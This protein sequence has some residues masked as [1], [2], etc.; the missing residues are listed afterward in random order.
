MITINFYGMYKPENSTARPVAEDRLFTLTGEFKQ[1]FDISRPVVIV[2]DP[3]PSTTVYGSTFTIGSPPNYAQINHDAGQYGGSFGYFWIDQIVWVSDK[4]VEVHMREDVLATWYTLIRDTTQYVVRSDYNYDGRIL[5]T[6]YPTFSAESSSGVDIGNNVP[7]HQATPWL[8]NGIFVVGLVN[9]DMNAFGGV[10]YYMFDCASYNYL[11]KVLLSNVS[12]TNMSFD[13]IEMSLYKSLFNPLQYIYGVTWFPN[14]V[15]SDLW[16]DVSNTLQH[17]LHFGWWDTITIADPQGQ[18]TLGFKPLYN[19][20]NAGTITLSAR[21]HAYA[22]TRGNYLNCPP[23]FNRMLYMPPFDSIQLD[24]SALYGDTDYPEVKWRV[25]FITG[26]ASIRVESHNQSG[27]V[28]GS[29]TC[30]MGVPMLIAQSTQD[31][32]GVIGG[33]AQAATG[34]VMAVGGVVQAFG[35]GA[36]AANAGNTVKGGF[37]NMIAGAHTLGDSIVPQ[38]VTENVQSSLSAFGMQCLDVI[39]TKFPPDDDPDR[40]GRPCH[41]LVKLS[42]LTPNAH[43]HTFIQCLDPHIKTAGCRIPERR[44]IEQWMAA[45]FYLEDFHPAPTP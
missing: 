11:R 32:I 10:S 9:D 15:I 14:G 5:D 30:K 44:E 36:G 35:G 33:A 37:Q 38:L 1:P 26:D 16:N 17:T 28:V 13:Q 34:G 41:K 40:F 18:A 20:Y 6:L 31:M 21:H 19:A 25:D 42:T 12:W 27:V 29:G 2:E 8:A 7:W 43:P 22:S 39:V 24:T 3:D 23:F 4:L 45:G